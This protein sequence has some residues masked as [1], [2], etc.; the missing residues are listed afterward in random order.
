MPLSA[1]GMLTLVSLQPT[2]WTGWA[3]NIL[4]GPEPVVVVVVVL[5]AVDQL[6]ME[7]F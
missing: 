4:E 1:P 7:L 3:I 5:A 2:P 6:W